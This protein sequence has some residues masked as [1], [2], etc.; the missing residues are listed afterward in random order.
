MHEWP[1]IQFRNC[2]TRRAQRHNW[3]D[4]KLF[5]PQTEGYWW[6]FVVL[7][8]LGASWRRAQRVMEIFRQRIGDYRAL[9]M[10]WAWMEGKTRRLQQIEFFCASYA[11]RCERFFWTDAPWGEEKAQLLSSSILDKVLCMK[12]PVISSALDV[13][14]CALLNSAP[15]RELRSV[16]HRQHK[17]LC[18]L[19]E[20]FL[21]D[22]LGKFFGETN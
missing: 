3:A 20:N 11:L 6:T 1:R 17:S 16:I 13:F 21:S 2:L 14:A 9:H 4:A 18:H 5:R 12:M 19:G 7:K 8:G 22:R 10:L 15:L